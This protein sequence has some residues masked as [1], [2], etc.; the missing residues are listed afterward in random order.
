MN[1]SAVSAV[2]EVVF[3]THDLSLFVLSVGY[4]QRLYLWKVLPISDA[5][6]STSN[7]GKVK[8]CNRHVARYFS[9]AGGNAVCIGDVAGMSIAKMSSHRWLVS[10]VGEGCQTYNIEF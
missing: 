1:D 9:L 8:E 7:S 3:I 10:V 5:D 4:D 6:D 2:K